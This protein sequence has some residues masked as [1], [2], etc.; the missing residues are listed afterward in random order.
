MHNPLMIKTNKLL[1]FFLLGLSS[2]CSYAQERVNILLIFIDDMGYGDL[3]CYGNKEVHTP[4]IDRLAQEGIRFRQFYVNSPICSPSRVAITTGQYPSRWG[5]TSY[6]SGRADNKERGMNHCLNPLAP[7]VARNL[8]AAGYY[9][10]HIGKWHMG[11]GRDVPDVPMITDYGF[12]ESVTQFEGLGERY[13]ATYETLNLK[14]STRGLEKQSAALG[15]GEVHWAKRENFTEIFVDRTME[16]INHAKAAGKPFYINLWPDDIHTPLEPPLALRGDLSTKARF[17]GVMQEMDRQ[18][19]R[20][21][22]F[23][24]NDPDLYKNTLVVFTSDN[25]PDMAVNDAAPLRGYKTF[26]YD[27]GIREP[28]IVWWPAEIDQEE[29][30]TINEKTVLAAIDLP[31][32]FMELAGAIPDPDVEYD[33]QSMLKVLKGDQE[34]LRDK[35][36]FWIRPPDRPGYNGENNPDLAIRSGNY[37]LLMDVDGTNVQ[38]YNL[39][40]D[41]GES[42]NL[43]EKMPQLTAELKKR[44]TDWYK[45]Y[46]H[47]V[48]KT[49]Y[50][51]HA[52]N[53]S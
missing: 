19:G 15:K 8:K 47:D 9:T 49:K 35:P 28:F 25:G 23:L 3:A 36:L 13:L 27:G 24:R 22:D 1:L 50:E 34:I 6:I 48:D 45:H 32:T 26:L 18:M 4:N 31:L 44:L 43:A 33:G 42:K 16:A 38:L 20:L 11:G 39:V 51:T 7:S 21:F 17:L 29:A 12:D 53:R 46:P 37:K 40:Q 5:I 2:L 10:A 30:G 41:I 14:D 52:V